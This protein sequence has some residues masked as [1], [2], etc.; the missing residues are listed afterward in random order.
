[1]LAQGGVGIAQEGIDHIALKR[2]GLLGRINKVAVL[3]DAGRAEVIGNTTQR[4][5]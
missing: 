4:H 5:H 1:M 3:G 2:F